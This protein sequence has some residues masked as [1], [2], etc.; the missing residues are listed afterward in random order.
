MQPPAFGL[1]SGCL[2]VSRAEGTDAKVEIAIVGG[3]V[4]GVELADELFNAAAAL[5]R[6]GLEVFNASRLL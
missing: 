6:Y 5:K 3:G 2:R 4:T 1:G